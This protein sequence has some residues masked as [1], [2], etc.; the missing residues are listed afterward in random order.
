MVTRLLVAR[1]VGDVGDRKRA[2]KE[3]SVHEV[4]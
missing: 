3:E 1:D 4:A 2:G